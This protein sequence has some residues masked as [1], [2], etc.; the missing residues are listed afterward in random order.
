MNSKSRSKKVRYSFFPHFICICMTPV[1]QSTGEDSLTG[2]LEIFQVASKYWLYTTFL[3]TLPIQTISGGNAEHQV[4]E[5]RSFVWVFNFYKH[6]SQTKGG[7]TVTGIVH[8]QF[9]PIAI[10]IPYYAYTFTLRQKLLQY[11]LVFCQYLHEVASVSIQSLMH[12]RNSLQLGPSTWLMY[13]S[14]QKATVCS[15]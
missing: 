7:T 14:I 13:S 1:I 5:G 15:H 3:Q 10:N 9:C 2:Y 6:Q 4:A 8:L 11:V 12:L